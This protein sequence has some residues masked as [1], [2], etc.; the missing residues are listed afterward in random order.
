MDPKQFAVETLALMPSWRC[1]IVCHHCVFSSAPHLRGRLEI[2]SALAAISELVRIS[3]LRRV[4]VSGGEPF[5]DAEYLITIA[6]ACVPLNLRFRAI[7]NCSFALDESVAEKAIQPLAEI[8]IETLGISWDAFH[9][10]FVDPLRVRNVIRA[11]RRLNVPVRLTAVVTRVKGLAEVL[12]PLGDEA[13]ELPITQVKCLPVGRAES[14]VPESELL[15]PSRGDIGRSCRS[16]FDTVSL[17]PNGDVFPCCAV[18][19]FTEGIRLGNFSTMTF[20]EMLKKR[21]WDSRWA[22][23]AS[24][25]PQYFLDLLS[26]DE[27]QR[28]QLGS[29]QHDCVTCN[30]LFRTPY[31][32]GLADRQANALK[33]QVLT[34]LPDMLFSSHQP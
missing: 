2:D 14:R 23:L 10:Q 19:G 18:G 5:L 8:G 30:K 25:G 13:Y 21:D 34:I 20:A 11:A 26:A 9:A 17:T 4:A 28:L 16:D 3:S 7:T 1:D 12:K 6:K 31:G 29:P 27:K 22:I 15:S 32:S 24:Q 33:S